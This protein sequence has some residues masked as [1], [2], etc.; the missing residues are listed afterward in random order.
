MLMQSQKEED[1]PLQRKHFAYPIRIKSELGLLSRNYWDS[2]G[3][4]FSV[5]EGI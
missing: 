1:K 5:L 4:V 2:K 3:L